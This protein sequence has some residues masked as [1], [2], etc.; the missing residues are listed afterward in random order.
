MKRVLMALDWLFWV[1][2]LIVCLPL[3]VLGLLVLLCV[4]VKVT[5]DDDQFEPGAEARV[6]RESKE[7]ETCKS[8]KHIKV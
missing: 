2:R 7:Q 8:T 3:I 5:Q 4:G 6:R 1:F